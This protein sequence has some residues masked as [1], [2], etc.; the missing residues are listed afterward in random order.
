M[1]CTASQGRG[2]AR[3]RGRWRAAAGAVTGLGVLVLSGCG[4]AVTVQGAPHKTDP[5]CASAMLA[6]PE[7][8]GDLQQRETTSQATT[9]YGD[10]SG[11]IVRCGVDE[12]G[13]TTDPCTEVNG[14]DWLISEVPDQDEQW[15]A[16]S[17]GRSPAVEV[18]FDT[19]R[20]SSSTALVGVASAVGQ[21]PQNRTCQSVSDTLEL[22]TGS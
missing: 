15:R 11:V 13:P 14:V 16:V 2:R 8:V 1:R 22:G 21:L 5:R 7:A 12:P 4:S 18:L 6:M 9:A 3:A 19:S 10:P 17:Y 20:V